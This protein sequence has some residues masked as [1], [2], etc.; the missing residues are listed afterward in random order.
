MPSLTRR[1]TAAN[2]AKEMMPGP[3]LPVVRPAVSRFTLRKQVTVAPRNNRL[4]TV[5]VRKTAANLAKRIQNIPG[6]IRSVQQLQDR[7]QILLNETSKRL[8]SIN[9][10]AMY[11]VLPPRFRTQRK[12]QLNKIKRSYEQMLRKTKTLMNGLD[13]EKQ[14]YN[15]PKRSALTVR[16]IEAPNEFTEVAPNLP[17]IVEEE[18][19][20][21]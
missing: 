14:R 19:R 2:L 9:H 17:G 5:R 1:K 10:N 3:R 6:H 21:I 20:N 15:N 8:K 16:S 12:I 4:H 11:N 18:N 13:R 7:Q